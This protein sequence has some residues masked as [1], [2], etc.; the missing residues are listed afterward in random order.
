MCFLGVASISVQAFAR[1]KVRIHVC[2]PAVVGPKHPLKLNDSANLGM[3]IRHVLPGIL[4]EMR[5]EYDWPNL[6]RTVLH[7]K[8]SYMVSSAHERVQVT[9]AK[10]L[11]QAGFV[12]WVGPSSATAEWLVPKWG[13]VYLHETVISHI[14]R[15][16]GTDVAY[17][18]LEESVGHFKRR[19]KAVEEHMNSPVFSSQGG[20]GLDGLARNLRAR[21]AE[22]VRRKGA[23]LPK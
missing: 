4:E 19:M 10:S 13:D 9:F 2:D 16:L 21:C 3:F 14:R 23:R 15:L 7:D 11:Q 6:P 5:S 22:V 18:G 20:R 17:A 12:S 8:A 1:G